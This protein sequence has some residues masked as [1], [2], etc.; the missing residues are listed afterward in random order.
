[1]LRIVRTPD[2]AGPGEELLARTPPGAALIAELKKSEC[3]DCEDDEQ[4]SQRVDSWF[5]LLGFYQFCF[6]DLFVRVFSCSF[7]DRFQ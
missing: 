3:E 6:A 2:I 5:R 7:V 1:M 4:R